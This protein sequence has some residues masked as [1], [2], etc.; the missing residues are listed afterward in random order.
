M[1]QTVEQIWRDYEVEGLPASGPHTPAKRE[2]RET[3]GAIEAAVDSFL[4][5][6]G[7]VYTTRAALFADL[8]HA[9]N[10]SAWVIGDGT[11]AYNGV[12]QKQGALGTGSWTRIA[13]L[14]Y[15]FIVAV[16]AGAGTANAITATSTLPISNGMLVVF[17]AHEANTSSP[18]TVA[19]NGAAARTI[20]TNT[21]SD[22]AAGGITAGMAV[23]GFTVSD[24]QFR[25][26]S[27]QASAAIQA[28]AEDAQAAAEAAAALAIAAADLASG[29]V[30]GDVSSYPTIA[31][32]EASTILAARQYIYIGGQDSVGDLLDMLMFVRVT[33][34]PGHDLS[35]RSTDRE[36]PELGG[37]DNATGGYWEARTPVLR[38]QMFGAVGDGVTDDLAALDAMIA[39]AVATGLP[40]RMPVAEYLT[41]DKWEIGFPFLKLDCEG[42]VI[43]KN[44]NASPNSIAVS[45][46]AGAAGFL[47][48]LEIGRGGQ[49]LV[50]GDANTT[51]GIYMRSVHH[52]YINGRVVNG[53]GNGMKVQ[54]GVRNDIRYVCSTNEE[55]FGVQPDQGFVTEDRDPGEGFVCNMLDV[56]VEGVALGGV[57][58]QDTTQ[59]NII[60]G[61]SEGNGGSGVE[62]ADTCEGNV[63]DGFHCEQNCRDVAGY[64]FYIAGQ[65]ASLRNCTGSSWNGTLDVQLLNATASLAI[66]NTSVSAENCFFRKIRMEATAR[67]WTFRNCWYYREGDLLGGIVNATA[68]ERGHNTGLRVADTLGSY[69]EPDIAPKPIVHNIGAV[70][71]I[72][73]ITQ[74]GPAVVQLSANHGLNIGQLV[75][76]AGITGMTELNGNTYR[77]VS[78]PAA[79]KIGLEGVDSTGYA[80]WVSG[81]T[82]TPQSVFTNSWVNTAGSFAVAGFTKT[83][84]GEVQLI[85]AIKDGSGANTTA[86]T[87]PAGYRPRGTRFF[88]SVNASAVAVNFVSVSAAGEV[89]PLTATANCCLDNIR[90]LAEN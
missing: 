53:A 63:F 58:L 76:I 45:I 72:I 28:A 31:L 43:I 18:V 23:M 70:G 15:N 19:F 84:D 2:I 6:G 12:Y 22:I 83:A 44:R 10:T 79:D 25:L 39:H 40:C 54:F 67:D 82:V 37:T 80:A 21:G 48:G 66:V 5:N 59:G 56:T 29:V 51:T 8:A 36:L 73:G 35:F 42:D 60:T 50:D 57:V 16:D 52:S 24:S 55:A 86:F 9:A 38:P 69:S 61:T 65:R 32:A 7:L 49:L 46:D 30:E 13:D 85:G 62:E 27:D 33:G 41:T 47:Y 26:L 87:L 89:K 17:I 11:V 1:P 78:V 88:A 14:P 71:T 74:A 20:K 77:I 4:A 90:F 81:G 3:L 64:D 68:S 75:S 34:D